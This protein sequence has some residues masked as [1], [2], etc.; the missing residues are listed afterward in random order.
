[1]RHIYLKLIGLGMLFMFNQQVFAYDCEID[2]IYYNI[3]NG[4]NNTKLAIVTY[5][6]TKVY[7]YSGDIRIPSSINYSGTTCEVI[8]IGTRA[9]QNCIEL[10]SIEIPN[11]VGKI[12]S[13]AFSGCTNITSVNI[14]NS[15]YSIDYYA[16]RNC[17]SLTTI[18]IPISVDFLGGNAF[19]GCTSLTSVII[20][21][22]ITKLLNGVF[23]GCTSLIDVE[24]P[25]NLTNI[26]GFN[27]CTSLKHIYIPNSVTSITGFSGCTNLEYIK[28]PESV[29]SIGS[30]AF[31][32]CTKL[33]SIEMG[34]N[35]TTIGTWAFKDCSSLVSIVL[36]NSVEKVESQA[37][38]GCSNL[39]YVEIGSNVKEIERMAF[40]DC[41]NL[42]SIVV[43]LN[44]SIYNDGNGNNCIVETQ[45]N[46]LILGCSTTAIPD[47][48][49]RIGEY[50]FRGCSNLTY[51]DIPNS[52]TDI[53]REA[54][55]GCS[56]LK[57]VVIPNSVISIGENAFYN[58]LNCIFIC[59]NNTPPVCG[60]DPFEFGGFASTKA[61]VPSDAVETYKNTDGWKSLKIN[62][63]VE[64]VKTTQ[65]TISIATGGLV[66]DVSTVC[67]GNTYYAYDDTITITGL[68][69]NTSYSFPLH[70]KDIDLKIQLEGKTKTIEPTI[71]VEKITNSTITLSG[72]NNAGDATIN[73]YGFTGYAEQKNITITGLTPDKEYTFTYYVVTADGT[74]YETKK[75]VTTIAVTPSVSVNTES[76][77]NTTVTLTGSYTDIGDAIVTDH[78]FVGY[79]GMD[80]ITV[81]GLKPGTEYT[82]TYFIIITGGTKY[83]TK[84]T[85]KTLTI[86]P[87]VE[88]E[89]VT[90]TTV[91]LKGKDGTEESSGHIVKEHGFEGHEGKEMV[92]ITGLAPGKEY[93]FTYYVVTTDGSRFTVDKTIA[94]KNIEVNA[95]S[96]SGPSH[97]F[98]TGSFENEDA[99][100]TEYG[101]DGYE[102]KDSLSL[103]GLDPDTEYTFTFYVESEEGGRQ[104]QD[105]T[106][107]T[108]KLT[109]TMLDPKTVKLGEVIVAAQTNLDDKETNVG[110]EWRREDWGDKFRPKN[111]G[112]IIY[113]G[114]IEGSIRDLNTD[115]LWLVKPYYL[116]NS[117]TYHY[118]EEIGI[119]PSDVSYFDPVVHTADNAEVSGNSATVQGYVINGSD[120]V[121][122][123]GMEYW[124]EM[125]GQSQSTTVET[126][127]GQVMSTNLTNLDYETTYDYV[128]FATTTSGQTYYG[129]VKKFKTGKKTSDSKGDVN[130]DGKVDISD[131]VAVINHIAGTNSYKQADVNGDT[132]VDIS[133]IVAIINIIAGN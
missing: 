71:N 133:D 43:N 6:E 17:T 110:F 85:I 128:A 55:Y 114:T 95:T 20:P 89:S 48:I 21:N 118:G 125:D 120:Q 83:E 109:M 47:G 99:T 53:E 36:P 94:T 126:A 67:N 45:S 14:P 91:K 97:L 116:S 129:E 79:E 38:R 103:Y 84:E 105:F 34:S 50:A 132:K 16:F 30:Q 9:F 19:S 107:K 86:D 31:D 33:S 122:S 92:I 12:G 88:V 78:G 8:E 11:S 81:T 22:S 27:G 72:M 60:Y 54:F 98:V 93:T 74:R 41:S 64:I 70:Y 10:K 113:Q 1:M 123:Q 106:F 117:G 77:T 66:N 124:K 15:V 127:G 23:N 102:N 32:G 101:F 61:I 104:T 44:N 75:T 68:K 100:I 7:S 18:N 4:S 49:Q 115:K 57:T 62:E 13:L 2:G 69:P 29:K 56:D 46:T 24:L 96:T 119:D 131:I 121:T 73:T 111:G 37:F 5:N 52:V 42:S 25:N 80:K 63:G 40:S 76:I 82:F 87:T 35:V 58:C 112:G 28:I 59:N 130:S 26:D 90:N 51:I 108:D 39:Q 3:L 65:T